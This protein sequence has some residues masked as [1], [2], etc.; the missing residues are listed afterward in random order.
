MSLNRFPHQS[1]L[2]VERERGIEKAVWA[3]LWAKDESEKSGE[4]AENL[5]KIVFPFVGEVG[6]STTCPEC[7]GQGGL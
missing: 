6:I 1:M 7:L 4:T 3:Q 5:T 2:H